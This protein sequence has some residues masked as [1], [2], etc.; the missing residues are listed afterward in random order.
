MTSDGLDRLRER[1][2]AFT[3]EISREGYLAHSGLKTTADL[4]VIY[5]KFRDV[6]DEESLALVQRCELS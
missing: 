3:E 5:E 4:Q 1:G 2:Q 6:L